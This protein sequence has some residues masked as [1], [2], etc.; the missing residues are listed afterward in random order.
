M[1]AFKAEYH[2]GEIELQ[3]KEISDAQFFKFDQLPEIP[4]KG[5]LLT[6]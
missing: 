2:S 1:V 4:F 6:Q 3:E 5:V